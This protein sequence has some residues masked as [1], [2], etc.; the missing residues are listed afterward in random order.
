MILKCIF[1]SELTFFDKYS[2]NLS[3][4]L[5]RE[6]KLFQALSRR[7]IFHLFVWHRQNSREIG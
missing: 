3:T 4:N 5:L 7:T 1:F 6:K 2:H